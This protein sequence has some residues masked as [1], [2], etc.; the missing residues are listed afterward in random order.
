[1]K[2]LFILLA[3]LFLNELTST[4]QVTSLRAEKNAQKKDQFNC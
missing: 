3:G 4:A 1:M 2:K